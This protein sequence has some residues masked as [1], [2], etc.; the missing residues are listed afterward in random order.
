MAE[1]KLESKRWWIAIAAV[2]MQVSLGTVYAWS[3]F[4]KPLMTAHGWGETQTQVTFM[5]CIGMIG[6]AA[7]FGGALVDKKGPRFVATLGGILFGIGT[8]L[9]GLADQTGS[10]VLLYLGFGFV[11]GL[12]NG[13]GYVTPIATLIRWFPDKRGLVTGLAVMGFGF[14]AFFMGKIAPGLVNGMGVANTF[15]ILGIVFLVLVTASAQLFKNPPKGWLPAGFT[16]PASAAS[17]AQ[18]LTFD[19]AV[20]TPQWWMLWAMLCLNISAGLGL[21]SQLSPMAQDII[22]RTQGITDPKVLALAGGTILAIASIFNG[23][24]RLFWAWLSDAIGRKNVFITMFLTQAI[25]YVLL[26]QLGSQFLFTIVACYLLA[27][28][29]GGFATMPAFA[30]DSFGPAYIGRVYGIMLTAWSVAGVIGPLV[31]AQLKGI[32]L[33]VAAGL[34]LVGF[35]IALAYKRPQLKKAA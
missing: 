3:V 6:I 10:I 18:S 12:G 22:G 24:G 9:A 2:V 32:A 23:L 11:A 31:F 15:Y 4:K 5:I 29:G 19:E 1:E 35:L 27:C 16:P 26:P 28:Y 20:K 17:A 21:L 8:L 13:F 34:L 7:A 14:G 30:A 33:Y 25:L